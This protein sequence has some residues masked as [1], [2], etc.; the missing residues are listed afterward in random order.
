M[1]YAQ[2]HCHLIPS[3]TKSSFL[4]FILLFIV[5]PAKQSFCFK[6]CVSNS[7]LIYTHSALLE[8]ALGCTVELWTE[9][10]LQLAGV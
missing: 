7:E 4:L 1:H 9:T 6:Q 8:M 10:P 3:F 5:F 2:P